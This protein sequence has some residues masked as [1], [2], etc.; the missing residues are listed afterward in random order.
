MLKTPEEREISYKRHMEWF[1]PTAMLLFGKRLK[2]YDNIAKELN[3]KEGQKILEIGAGYPFYKRYSKRVG[4]DGLFVALD[5]NFK[6][7]KRSKILL[8]KQELQ[9]TGDIHNLPFKNEI[10][11]AIVASNVPSVPA[12]EVLRVLK[13]GGKYI[14][15]WFDTPEEWQADNSKKFFTHAGFTN[16]SVGRDS[17]KTGRFID[18]RVV[19]FKPEAK[20]TPILNV[21]ARK[22]VST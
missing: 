13:P 5:N 6:I 19:A 2:H 7:Q 14:E 17:W 20:Y 11:D 15:T 4:K 9:V 18:K 16:I 3:I 22:D 21:N 12:E 10:F 8:R 1:F